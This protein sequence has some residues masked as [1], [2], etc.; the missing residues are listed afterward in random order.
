VIHVDIVAARRDVFGIL[1][2]ELVRFGF[3]VHATGALPL[4]E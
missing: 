3:F 1:F 2:L 4:H